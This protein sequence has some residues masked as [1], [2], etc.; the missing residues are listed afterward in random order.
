MRLY[1]ESVS[2]NDEA[3]E[4]MNAVVEVPVGSRNKY[5]PEIGLILRDRV[6]P[7]RTSATRPTTA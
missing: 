6:L 2:I 1:L 3:P 4:L 7:G 5:E